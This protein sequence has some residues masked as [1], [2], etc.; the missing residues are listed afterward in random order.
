MANSILTPD[1][2]ANEALR[3]LKNNLVMPRMVNRDYQDEFVNVG[4]NVRVEKPIRY[5]VTDGKTFVRQ[6]VEMGNTNVKID[7]RKHVGIAFDSQSLSLDPVS[8]GQKFIE[9]GISQ[10]AHQVDMDILGLASDVPSWAGTL[11]RRSTALR[12]SPKV[13]SSS[14][15]SVCRKTTATRS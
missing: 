10:L 13:P 4:D 15:S 3:R 9:P 8:F 6:D 14:M 2:I 5:E 1:V 12:T 11:A 7:K